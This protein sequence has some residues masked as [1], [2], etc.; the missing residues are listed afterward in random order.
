MWQH[1]SGSGRCIPLSPQLPPQEIPILKVLKKRP[2]AG[3]CV[4]V[5]A[6][7][8]PDCK[9]DELSGTGWLAKVVSAGR[10][11]AG[12]ADISFLYARDERGRKFEDVRLRLG[13]LRE[14]VGW[15]GPDGGGTSDS[16]DA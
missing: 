10:P 4:V 7:T 13:D 14:I 16:D 1:G 5:L 12:A 6:A 3:T 15:S 8:W 2:A 9:C 11:Q